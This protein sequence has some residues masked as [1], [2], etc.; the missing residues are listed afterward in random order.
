MAENAERKRFV[1]MK[2]CLCNQRHRDDLAIVQDR[3]QAAS[4]PR[5]VLLFERLTG[6]IDQHKPEHEAVYPALIS[7]TVG[8]ASY[9]GA[10]VRVLPI[11]RLP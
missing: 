4:L 2:P 11:R 5:I 7:D 10:S 1:T 6:A 8:R 3:G 9:G